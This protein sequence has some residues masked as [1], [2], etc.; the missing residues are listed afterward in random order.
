MAKQK[1]KK[2]RVEKAKRLQTRRYKEKFGPAGLGGKTR[3]GGK[4]KHG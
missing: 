2:Q 4:G 3:R 1:T